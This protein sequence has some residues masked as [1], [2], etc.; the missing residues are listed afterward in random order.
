MK[1][2]IGKVVNTHGIRGELKSIVI[3]ILLKNVLK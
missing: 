3:Q 1:I 2:E